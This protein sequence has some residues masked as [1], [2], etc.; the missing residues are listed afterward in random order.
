MKPTKQKLW[1]IPFFCYVGAVLIYLAVCGVRLFLDTQHLQDGHLQER[2]LQFGQ[3]YVQGVL[4]LENEEGGTDL[5]STDPDPRMIYSPGDPFYATL[6]TFE[7]E[8]VSRPGGEMQLYYITEQG[9]EFGVDRS[10]AAQQ[11]ADGSWYF[12]L[13]GRK[14]HALRFDL[15][16]SG[17]ILYRNW[18][19]TL[20]G[21]KPVSDYFVPD[22]KEVFWLLFL[23][24]L[25]SGLILE[26]IHL[27]NAFSLWHKARE[28]KKSGA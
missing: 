19:I 14:V 8:E 3:F 16:T 7:A 22:A 20:N 13:G 18:N 24:L 25:L 9:E 28:K 12:D 2:T 10:Q 15:D 6:F 4:L 1:K 5:V 11:A 27:K 23:P 26:T 17:G 21:T